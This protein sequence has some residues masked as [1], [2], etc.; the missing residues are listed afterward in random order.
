M[1]LESAID[2]TV[3]TL[4]Q[5]NRAY[6]RVVFD[7]WAIVALHADRDEILS[8]DGP[9]RETIADALPGDLHHLREALAEGDHLPGQFEFARA[10]AGATADAFLAL[11]SCIYLIC[12]N[13]QLTMG[14][15]A[16]DPLWKAAQG[17]FVDLTE[18][19]AQDPIVREV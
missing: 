14:Q 7:E 12:N 18:R 9:R 3:K 10:A 6:R 15:I 8:Y 5:M 13:T 11:G 4:G 19:V 17:Y 16:A 2:R 1:D